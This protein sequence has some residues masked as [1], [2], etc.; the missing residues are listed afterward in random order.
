MNSPGQDPGAVTFPHEQYEALESA[1]ME[2]ARGRWF[3][4]EYA[5]R[6]RA[7][8]TMMLLDALKKLENVA[9]DTAKPSPDIEELAPRSR[10]RDRKLLPLT[11]TG[12]PMAAISPTMPDFTTASRPMREPRRARS[13]SDR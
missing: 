2:S 10:P 3:L 6:N 4:A 8:D 9:A 13:P 12:C 5:R 7:A 1:V 11:M